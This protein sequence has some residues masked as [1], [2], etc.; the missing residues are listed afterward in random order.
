MHILR[1]GDHN[2]PIPKRQTQYSAG[3]DLQSSVTEIMEPDE[4]M[5]I[6]VGFAFALPPGYVGFICPRSGLAL[7]YGITVTNAPGVLDADYRGQVRV[8]LEN[9][10]NHKYTVKPGDRIAQLV[11]AM[12]KCTD[13]FVEVEDLDDTDRGVGGFGSTGV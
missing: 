3:Y 9:R 8:I 5:A 2:L 11:I 10:G 1:M 6:P 4:R 7:N 12:I 13:G